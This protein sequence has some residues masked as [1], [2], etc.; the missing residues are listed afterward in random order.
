MNIYKKL[1]Q[2]YKI[3]LLDYLKYFAQENIPT[4]E[5]IY[6]DIDSFERKLSEYFYRCSNGYDFKDTFGDLSLL[7]YQY[8]ERL[9]KDLEKYY[10]IGE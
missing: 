9:H 1:D 3:T 2:A 6:I 7:K 4:N 8:S 5:P 10:N